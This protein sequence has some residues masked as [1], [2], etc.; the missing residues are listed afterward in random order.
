AIAWQIQKCT[1]ER[2]VMYCSAEQFMY[3]FI[4][5]LRHRNMMDFKHLFRSVDVLMIDDV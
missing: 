1:P 5:A 4:S 2:R 3:K